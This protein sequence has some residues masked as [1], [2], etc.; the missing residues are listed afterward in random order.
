[1]GSDSSRAARYN[2]HHE[3]SDVAA[4]LLGARKVGWASYCRQHHS[5]FSDVLA[6]IVLP[7]VQGEVT[8]TLLSRIKWAGVGFRF[9]DS[10]LK[11]IKMQR[12]KDAINP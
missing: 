5:V 10:L 6:L 1:M 9:E 7:Q 12:S 8:H 3:G 11:K 4:S 2:S